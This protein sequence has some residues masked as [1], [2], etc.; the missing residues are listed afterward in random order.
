MWHFDLI[1]SIYYVSTL[2]RVTKIDGQRPMQV[3]V[4]NEFSRV[5]EGGPELKRNQ[6]S[7]TSRGMFVAV[8]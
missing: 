5:I 7:W 8:I 3:N 1:T 2:F 4:R 6:V